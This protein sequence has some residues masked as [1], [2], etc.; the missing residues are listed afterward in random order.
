MRGLLLLPLCLGGCTWI[1][2]KWG[3]AEDIAGDY[4]NPLV[5][6]GLLLGVAEPESDEID[7]SDTEYGKGAVF[8]LFLADATSVDDLENAVLTGATV[9][10]KSDTNNILQASDDGAGLYTLTADAGLEYAPGEDFTVTADVGGGTGSVSMAAA[11]PVSLDLSYTHETGESL[12]VDLSSFSYDSVL[13]V[14]LD[15]FSG[16]VTFSNRPADIMGIYD[17]THGDEPIKR[18]E[19]PGSAFNAPEGSVYAV[20][21][22]GMKV[23]GSDAYEGMNTLLSSMMAGQMVFS[24][25]STLPEL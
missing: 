6:E 8:S 9:K 5:G 14:V 22:A 15:T 12:V 3:E 7:L 18:V 21:V 17:F 20:G 10:F 11:Q 24:A 25:V 13:V 1:E 2:E 19:I 23:A 16:E 4:L